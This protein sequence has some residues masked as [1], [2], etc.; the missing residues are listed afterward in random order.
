MNATATTPTTIPVEIYRD[1][2]DYLNEEL[3]DSSDFDGDDGA[4]SEFIYQS[5]DGHWLIT[6]E[7]KA[8]SKYIDE[9]FDH[10][11]GTEY[12]GYW[13]MDQLEDVTIFESSYFDDDDKETAMAFDFDIFD[14][15]HDKTTIKRGGVEI[16]AGDDVVVKDY[17]NGR[18]Q[19]AKFLY[20]DTI[21]ESYHWSG[22]GGRKRY[23]YKLLPATEENRKRVGTY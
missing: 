18:W 13:D 7:A 16:N 5:D 14:H 2:F 11:F 12:C 4:T 23:G 8:S 22:E 15:L 10:A 3:F 17:M 6:G 19:L 20:Y 9:S 21:N 1:L